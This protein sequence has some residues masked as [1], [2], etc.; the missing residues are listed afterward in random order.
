MNS[1]FFV[2][3]I[4]TVPKNKIQVVSRIGVV[5]KNKLYVY[6]ENFGLCDWL[7]DLF[8]PCN[9][10]AV[11]FAHN[12]SNFDSYFVI[13]ALSYLDIEIVKL[14]KKNNS[15]IFLVCRHNN[16]TVYFKDSFLFYI[17]ISYVPANKKHGYE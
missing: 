15:I 6:S 5:N 3:D 9:N 7:V 17:Y 10:E 11:I 2:F 12:F 8:I 16:V 13:K 4:E 1:N 14:F